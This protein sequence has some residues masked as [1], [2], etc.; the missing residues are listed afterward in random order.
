MIADDSGANLKRDDSEDE[1]E[2]DKEAT[3]TLA[4]DP[5]P[6]GHGRGSK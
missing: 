2:Q 6:G 3:T 4:F 5:A 1:L